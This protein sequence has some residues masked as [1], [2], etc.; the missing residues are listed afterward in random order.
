M[1]GGQD[2]FMLTSGFASASLVFHPAYQPQ[3]DFRYLGRQKVNGRDHYVIAFAQQPAKA[4]LNGAFRSGDRTMATFSQG[5]AWIDPQS[6]QITRL[7]TDLLRPLPEV[8]LQRETT[9][10][11]Y[12]EVH[13]KGTDARFWVPQ[14]VT[15]SVDWNG[16]HLRNEHR[17]SEFKL[18]RVEANEKV[19]TRREQG[20]TPKPTSD[21][22]ARR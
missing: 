4:R 18:F 7:R 20:Q 15:V 12:S 8:N 14:Q 11:V 17:Y 6:Y 2:G 21:P 10:I 22:P 5:L 9:E 3:A 19:G 13:F 1:R 16:K